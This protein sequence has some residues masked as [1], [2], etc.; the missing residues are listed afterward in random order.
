M[1]WGI[2]LTV[3]GLSMSSHTESFESGFN[4]IYVIK[5]YGVSVLHIVLFCLYWV[6]S[7]PLVRPSSPGLP[8]GAS[9]FGLGLGKKVRCSMT[10]VSH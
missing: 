8:Q 1:V 7:I 5:V 4:N 10:F 9:A 6:K 2:K 3:C